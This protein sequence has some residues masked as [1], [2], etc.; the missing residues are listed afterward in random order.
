MTG[1]DRGPDPARPRGAEAGPAPAAR[2]DWALSAILLAALALGAGLAVALWVQPDFKLFWFVGR[3]PALAY[4]IEAVHTPEFARLGT[5]LGPHDYLPFGYPPTLL[6]LLGPL[7]LLPPLA[8]K[9]LWSGGW[10]AAF[11]WTAWRDTRRATALL[12]LSLPLLWCAAI[13]QT[14]LMISTLVIAGFQRLDD[15]PRLA[16]AL[17]AVAACIK[18]QALLLA[19]IVLWGRWE[20]VRAALLAAVALALASLV[21]GPDL[22]LQ[23][24][25]SL[26]RFEGIVAPGY[27]KVGPGD[28]LPG[29]GWRVLLSG[30]GLVFAWRRRD[31]TGLLAGGLL[32]APY[33]QAYDLAGLSFLGATLVR[34]ARREPAVVVV[35]GVILTLCVPAP[36]L[37]TLY[38]AGLATISMWRGTAGRRPAAA[39]AAA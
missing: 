12:L 15:R 23:W 27:L 9:M 33:V 21:F 19:P 4:D 17:L 18:P 1:D 14:G 38:C 2:R 32:C 26:P 3:H 36:A 16:G 22:W 13:G 6:L 34:D 39:Q 11:A 28:L 20:V 35:F 5:A 30:A 29:L 24:A 31:L 8:A 7:S 10:C 37:T 25:R